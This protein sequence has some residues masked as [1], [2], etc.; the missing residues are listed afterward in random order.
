MVGQKK[1]NTRQCQ[2][3]CFFDKEEAHLGARGSI[4]WKGL[5]VSRF[6]VFCFLG[7]RFVAFL[8]AWFLGFK[9]S[10][11]QRLKCSILPRVRSMFVGGNWWYVRPENMSRTFQTLGNS[12]I[13]T[14]QSYDSESED[15]GGVCFLYKAIWGGVAKW[16][17]GLVGIICFWTK[18]EDEHMFRWPAME[19]LF[20]IILYLFWRLVSFS[21]LGAKIVSFCVRIASLN[22][23][24]VCYSVN[25][26]PSIVKTVSKWC[27]WVSSSCL[28]VQPHSY[29]AI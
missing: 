12:Q 18:M 10:K 6:L 25:I 13:A 27:P 16:Y 11:L 5:S 23:K 2:G 7:F 24:I 19:T 14:I 22:V 29:I 4:T 28:L 20:Q 21:V 26:V 3:R 17:E 9:V 1:T 8:V 15:M